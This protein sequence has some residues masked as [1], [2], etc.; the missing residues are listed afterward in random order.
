MVG[1]AGIR[2]PQ[3]GYGPHKEFE[4]YNIFEFH[5]RSLA[6]MLG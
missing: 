5:R 2:D 4:P 6:S 3:V 1:A